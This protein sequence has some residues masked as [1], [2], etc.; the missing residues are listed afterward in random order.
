MTP[1]QIIVVTCLYFVALLIVIYFMRATAW[2]VAG[3]FVGGTYLVAGQSRADR[4]GK[5]LRH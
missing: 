5:R 4:L 1:L 2:R 3:A